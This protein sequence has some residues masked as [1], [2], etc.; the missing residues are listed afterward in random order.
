M[1]LAR[2]FKEDYTRYE[3]LYKEAQAMRD[4]SRKKDTIEQ[5]ITLHQNL[6]RLKREIT[7]LQAAH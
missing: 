6:E 1:K 2:K 7:S 4:S 3:R 5:V